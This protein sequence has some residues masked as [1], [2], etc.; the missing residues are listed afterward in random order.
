MYDPHGYYKPKSVYYSEQV[1]G[2]PF[3]EDYPV[4][5]LSFGHRSERFRI[6]RDEEKNTQKEEE[7]KITN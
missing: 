6:I 3:H 5:D 2:V 7:F 1:H 4:G